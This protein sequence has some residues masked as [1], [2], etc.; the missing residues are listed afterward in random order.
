MNP[1]TNTINISA[2]GKC[3]NTPPEDMDTLDM[4]I[5]GNLI[6]GGKNTPTL[7]G[8]TGDHLP[9]SIKYR[10]DTFEPQQDGTCNVRYVQLENEYHSSSLTPDP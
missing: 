6:A 5:H 9:A 4:I 10:L 7:S 3:L 8:N 1:P 2:D